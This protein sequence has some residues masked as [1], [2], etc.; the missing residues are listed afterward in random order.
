M[1]IKVLP[2]FLMAFFVVSFSQDVSVNK[3]LKN[4][5]EV[6]VDIFGY[7]GSRGQQI[8]DRGIESILFFGERKNED[9]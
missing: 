7:L 4:I 2:N 5:C 6:L 8:M 1:M 3:A 9:Q